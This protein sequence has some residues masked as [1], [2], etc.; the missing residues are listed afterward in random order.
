M[1]GGAR[2]RPTPRT[3][4]TGTVLFATTVVA[5]AVLVGR[6]SGGRLTALGTLPVRGGRLVVGALAVQLLGGYVGG[7]A[8]PVGLVV[9]V[10]TLAEF[11]RRNRGLTGLGLVT[12]GLALNALVVAANGAM[13]VSPDAAG[14]AGVSV[15]PLLA[16]DD[17]RHVLSDDGTALAL[18]GDV[19]PVLL[20]VRP[21]VVSPGDVCLV[22][23]LAQLVVVGMR[24]RSPV[25]SSTGAG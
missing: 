3:G 7:W 24:R 13:P 19:V 8:Y 16:G 1:Y 5:A 17:P 25:A 6:L 22:A 23:G 10:V 15:Q 18:L 4:H 9:S 21:E 2:A 12:V 14:R 20:P 11:L